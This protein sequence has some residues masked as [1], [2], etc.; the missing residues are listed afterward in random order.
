MKVRRVRLRG[1]DGVSSAVWD[2]GHWA[3]LVPALIRCRAQKRADLASL[4]AVSRDLGSSFCPEALHARRF[5][6][7]VVL[8]VGVPAATRSA[9][10][11]AALVRE[12][13]LRHGKPCGQGTMAGMYHSLGEMLAYAS[14]GE[15][16]LPG[17]LL[18]TGTIRNVIGTPAP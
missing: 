3:P 13:H 7:R 2:E 18:A 16:V 14:L 6:C 12:A 10:P 9:A 8:R 1:E 17:E 5:A 11:H 4:A 15:R